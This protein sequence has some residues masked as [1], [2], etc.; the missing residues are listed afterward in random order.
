MQLDIRLPIG[1]L[2]SCLGTLLALYGAT[3]SDSS[4]SQGHNVNFIWGLVILGFGIVM[5]ALWKFAPSGDKH[6]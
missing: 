6:E 2:F 4:M 3:A 5:L 1:L